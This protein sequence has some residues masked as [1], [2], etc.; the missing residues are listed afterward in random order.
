[1]SKY[2][3][4]NILCEN[5]MNLKKGELVYFRKI[6][7]KEENEAIQR[8][9]HISFKDDKTLT[10][11]IRGETVIINQSNCL[12]VQVPL[13]EKR[14]FYRITG[15]EGIEAYSIGKREIKRTLKKRGLNSFLDFVDKA[16][17]IKRLDL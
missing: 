6:S 13:F 1:M 7:D 10:L 12:G 9:S 16:S 15:E 3:V 14:D 17:R 4:Y 8:Y 5:I 2:E 11:E